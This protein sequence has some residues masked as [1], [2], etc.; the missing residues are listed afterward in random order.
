MRV[1]ENINKNSRTK[2]R[3]KKENENNARF[4][5]SNCLLCKNLI[6]L[7]FAIY[8]MTSDKTSGAIY[9]P[10]S[11]PNTILEL[12]RPVPLS[13]QSTNTKNGYVGAVFLTDFLKR[14]IWIRHFIKGMF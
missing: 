1:Y 8:L 9:G 10:I 6:K 13:F 4:E 14:H 12:L 7:E 5:K 11:L 2:R 3:P